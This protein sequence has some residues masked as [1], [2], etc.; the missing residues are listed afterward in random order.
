[1]YLISYNLINVE[2]EGHKEGICLY[3]QYVTFNDMTK[4]EERR[5]CVSKVPADTMKSL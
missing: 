3:H 4:I 5:R 2:V 1:M